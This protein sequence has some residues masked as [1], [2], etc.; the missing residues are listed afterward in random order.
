MHVL[1]E[2]A[3]LLEGSLLGLEQPVAGGAR[4]L[5]VVRVESV[6]RD[7]EL[8][9]G[10]AALERGEEAVLDEL[11]GWHLEQRLGLA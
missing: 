5:H 7:R 1:D 3:D 6:G 9:V 10:A 8:L 11:I 2:L 4:G